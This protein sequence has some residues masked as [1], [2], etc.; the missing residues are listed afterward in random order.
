[1]GEMRKGD[2]SGDGG[3]DE[4]KREKQGSEKCEMKYVTR[5]REI[6]NMETNPEWRKHKHDEKKQ[7]EKIYNLKIQ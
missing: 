6:A 7:K 3:G 1:M 5:R 4:R 2:Q